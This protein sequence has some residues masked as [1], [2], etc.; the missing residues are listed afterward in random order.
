MTVSLSLDRPALPVLPLRRQRNL[1]GRA[2]LL[3]A[4][5]VAL[6]ALLPLGF[7][8]WIARSSNEFPPRN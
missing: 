1:A 7:I 6:C 3:L 5:G 8:L 2:M 4:G